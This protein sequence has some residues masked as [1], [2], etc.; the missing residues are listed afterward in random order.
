MTGNI[1]WGQTDRGINWGF[2][3]DGAYIKFFNTGNGDTDS[4]LEYATFDDSNEYHRWLISSAE[5]MTLKSDGLRVTDS[6]WMGGNLVATQTWVTN[7][8]ATTIAGLLGTDSV[9]ANPVNRLGSGY[10]QQSSTTTANGWP[11]N[12]SW[13]HLHAVTHSNTANYYSMQ[14]AADFYSNTLYYRSTNNS[15]T[16]A[17]SQVVLNSGTW[18][19]SIS[20]SAAQLGGADASRF[21]LGG[22]GL[23]RG[24]NQ[25]TDWNQSTFP[26]AAFLSSENGVTNAPSTDYT[27]GVQTSF[28]RS[29]PDYRTQFVT[30][31]YG[32]NVYWLR[33]LR[34]T[35]GWSSWVTVIHS[36]NYNSY[37]PTL[38][39]GGAS[40][41]WSISITGTAGSETLSTVVS[42][43]SS[44]TG[45]ISVGGNL[46]VSANNTAGGG[47]ILAD[48]G[49]IVDLNDAYC[50]MRFT[51]G[52][53]I[54]SANRG[55]SAVITL[56]N[57]G[58]IT[59]SSD[60]TAYSDVRLKTLV[61]TIDNAI[62]KVRAL[63]GV[64]Y[65]RTDKE[66]KTEKMGV[67][68]QE[69]MEVIPQVV[70]QNDDGYHTVAY[71][72]MVGLLIEAIKEQQST[73]DRLQERINT[74]EKR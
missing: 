23:R 49:D 32:N 14:F 73:I 26:D 34:D 65:V 3:T 64:T 52:V 56:S 28:H 27:Y 30:S 24:V 44:T 17:W 33:Q 70:S 8:R 74:L 4:R 63:R 35:A 55:G 60:V 1:S 42:R 62:Q 67:I 13:Y 29:G 19:I 51:S 46:T 41:T 5:E 59:A 37:S 9:D 69:V 58:S 11:V 10:Y 18:S 68:A 48:D 36:G 21:V 53:R 31:L 7:N 40:G 22:S 57:G 72:N 71:G 45:S 54:F 47:I 25:V 66:D 43:G 61:K 50:S 15:G 6:I 2:N 16:G 39:G 12:G 20:G 38:T